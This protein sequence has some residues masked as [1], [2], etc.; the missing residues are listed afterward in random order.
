MDYRITE[1]GL[2][3]A[4]APTGHTYVRDATWLI[5]WAASCA[6][7]NRG[8]VWAAPDRPDYEERKTRHV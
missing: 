4:V 6:P 3:V 2:V 8:Y 7:A 5:Q 1:T